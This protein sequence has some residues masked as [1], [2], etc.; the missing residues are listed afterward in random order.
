MSSVVALASR[1][2]IVGVLALVVLVLILILFLALSIVA[3]TVKLSYVTIAGRVIVILSL[4]CL[5]T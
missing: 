2:N 5:Q 4:M 1:N 3:V